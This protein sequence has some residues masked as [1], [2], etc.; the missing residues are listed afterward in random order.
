[1]YSVDQNNFLW[2]KKKKSLTKSEDYEREILWPQVIQENIRILEPFFS[3][4]VK[5]SSQLTVEINIA[6]IAFIKSKS[7]VYTQTLEHN[8]N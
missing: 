6:V 4:N 8:E 1:M 5:I 2:L 7:S 3:W